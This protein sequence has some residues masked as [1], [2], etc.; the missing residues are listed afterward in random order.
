MSNPEK[1]YALYKGDKL[2]AIGTEK[3][4]A[5]QFDVKVSTIH[6][7]KSPTYIK[8]TNEM[9]ARRLVEI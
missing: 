5:E 2:L 6:F 9:K 4:L 1:E 3:E 8:R 7:Y